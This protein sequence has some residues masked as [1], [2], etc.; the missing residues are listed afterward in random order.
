MPQ[1]H[2]SRDGELALAVNRKYW[3]ADV[4]REDLIAEFRGW[5]LR[6]SEVI[7]DR[8]LTE[9]R[10]AMESESPIPGAFAG[11]RDQVS[12]FVENLIEGR[13]AG[14]QQEPY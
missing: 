13:A 11:L 6:D 3:H 7:V 1:A 14:E 8:A 2:L 5:G 4:T 9:L 12:G 10:L